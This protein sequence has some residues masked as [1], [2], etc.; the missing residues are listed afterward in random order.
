MSKNK[1][2]KSARKTPLPGVSGLVSSDDMTGLMPTLA[3]SEAEREA[4]G[5][6]Y[7]VIFSTP[8]NPEKDGRA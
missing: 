2:R 3:G 5:Q 8:Q 4:Y 1:K 7:P 6:L